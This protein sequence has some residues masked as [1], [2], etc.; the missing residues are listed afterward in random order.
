MRRKIA[1]TGMSLGVALLLAAPPA[2][3]DLDNAGRFEVQ[4]PP[5]LCEIQWDS[6]VCQGQFPQ[7]PVDPI[8]SPG[9]K[10]DPESLHQDQAVV[11]SSGQFSYRDANIGVGDHPALNTLTHGQEVTV[12][13]WTVTGRQDAVNIASPVGHG[14]QIHTDGTVTSF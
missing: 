6:A 14:M 2:A 12:Q 13:G 7:A 3:A 8:P 4:T 11:T 9:W 5:L 1:L 10:G